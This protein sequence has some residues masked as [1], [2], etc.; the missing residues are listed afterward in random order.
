MIFLNQI[1]LGRLQTAARKSD[2]LSK[3]GQVIQGSDELPVAFP[4]K[5]FEAY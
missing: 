2:N 1:F 5:L 3:V 4:D